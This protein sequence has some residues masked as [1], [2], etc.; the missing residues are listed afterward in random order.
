MAPL[1]I[2]IIGEIFKGL[3][4]TIDEVHTSEDERLTARQKLFEQQALIYT[5]VMDFESRLVEAQSRIV[6]AEAKSESWI[7]ANWRPLAM[8]VFTALI[9]NRWTG[10]LSIIGLPPIMIDAEIEK[11]LW[12][13][14]QVGLGGYVAGRS[15]EKVAGALAPT[16]GTY[17]EKK[18][19]P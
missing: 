13:V 17:I 4:N 10:I 15:L 2:P 9:V 5:R 14:I 19:A 7:A 16:L 18:N 3:F 1:L 11:E 8:L 12:T 6:E